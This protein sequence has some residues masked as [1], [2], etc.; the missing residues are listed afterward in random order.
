MNRLL[1]STIIIILALYIINPCSAEET[2]SSEHGLASS[3]ESLLS[4]D[5]ELTPE[6]IA[7]DFKEDYQNDTIASNTTAKISKKEEPDNSWVELKSGKKLNTLKSSLDELQ[8]IYNK[9]YRTF[10]IGEAINS[11]ET[12]ENQQKRNASLLLNISRQQPLSVYAASYI[13]TELLKLNIELF[14]SKLLETEKNLTDEIAETSEEVNKLIGIISED[15]NKYKKVDESYK[16]LISK[17]N[18]NIENI[19]KTNNKLHD[20]ANIGFYVKKKNNE[21]LDLL[22]EQIDSMEGIIDQLELAID[23]SQKQISFI[24]QHNH[25]MP[26]KLKYIAEIRSSFKDLE[27]CIE[28][29]DTK[30]KY[31]YYL[32]SS[33]YSQYHDELKQLIGKEEIRS[34][35]INSFINK[36]K[37][38]PVHKSIDVFNAKDDL[39]S[40]FNLFAFTE[41]DE[42]LYSSLL[43]YIGNESWH[44]RYK[45]EENENNKNKTEEKP[46]PKLIDFEEE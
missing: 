24:N 42:K 19:K 13:F 1:T 36:S 20:L 41:T 40:I 27:K 44:C 17:I 12:S 3:S 9:N 14:S 10:C 5:S 30:Q 23:Y 18:N 38:A 46:K 35:R 15:I 31:N 16:K 39:D 32:F 6:A 33:T 4:K 7:I 34:G 45:D 26:E 37:F 11:I 29:Y 43:A 2:E 22:K 21:I 25:S 28:S 8:N